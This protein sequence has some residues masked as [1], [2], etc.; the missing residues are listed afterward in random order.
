LVTGDSND[1]DIKDA[2]VDV[3][4]A[5]G[6]NDG[7]GGVFS[8]HST[9]GTVKIN[10]FT[11]SVSTNDNLPPGTLLMIVFV[12]ILVVATLIH[13]LL[14]I[15]DSVAGSRPVTAQDHSNSLKG[16]QVHVELFDTE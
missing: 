5:I 13:W 9:K 10:F 1:R 3:L 16:S 14:L 11:G 4:W 7:S 2:T 8:Q 6:T 15:V 12:P